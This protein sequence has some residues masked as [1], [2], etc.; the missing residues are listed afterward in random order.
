[1]QAQ[2]CF[3]LC[4]NN[5]SDSTAEI[6]R[7]GGAKVVREPFNQISRAR[8]T[9]A[10]HAKGQWL[11]FIDAD[12]YPNE[13]L[14]N[15][16]FHLIKED[17]IIGA[18]ATLKAVDGPLWN[19]LR[20]ERMNFFMR[21]FK[22]SSGAFILCPKAV[23]DKVGGFSEDLFALEEIEF[24]NRLKAWGKRDGKSF[25]ILHKHPVHTSARKGELNFKA[26]FELISSTVISVLYLISFY[27]LPKQIR[28]KLKAR[29]FSF[30]YKR[31]ATRE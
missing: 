6:A 29:Y 16:I 4:D 24:V 5:S 27:I 9:G 17:N 7:R 18:G 25:R 11:L 30:W 31:R 2:L 20:I 19:R 23:F 28:P 8:N 13:K 12:T 22:W 1:M 14:M 10:T 26:L 3:I 15:E 21:C